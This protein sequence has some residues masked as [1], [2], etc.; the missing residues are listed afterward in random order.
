PGV[1]VRGLSTHH[2]PLTFTM[3]AAGNAVSVRFEPGLRTPPGGIVLRSP[4]DRPVRSATVDGRKVEVFD[5]AEV[6]LR[7]LPR[8]VELRY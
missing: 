7:A 1:S 4:L 6:R 8:R 5:G 3:R 2:G